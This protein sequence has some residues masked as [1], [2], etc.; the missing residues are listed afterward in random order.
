[1]ANIRS[2]DVRETSERRKRVDIFASLLI[3]VRAPLLDNEFR[4]QMRHTCRWPNGPGGSYNEAI[5]QARPCPS[6]SRRSSPFPQRRKQRRR[7]RNILLYWPVI[8]FFLGLNLDSAF[9]IGILILGNLPSVP[10]SFPSA[11]VLCIS[12]PKLLPGVDGESY[13]R[14]EHFSS[15]KS[16]WMT[17]KITSFSVLSVRGRNTNSW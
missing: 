14:L 12:T 9:V 1:M 8:Y 16:I 2:A 7:C 5:N 3:G 10:C 6:L 17:P 13:R 4:M 11:Q 15:S